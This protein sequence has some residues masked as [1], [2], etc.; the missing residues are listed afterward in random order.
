MLL[1]VNN[2]DWA[3]RH[4]NS[5]AFSAYASSGFANVEDLRTRVSNGWSAATEKL[6]DLYVRIRSTYLCGPLSK[7]VTPDI[8]MSYYLDHLNS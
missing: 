1:L 8:G 5:R 3:A 2:A 4:A 6:I 7:E